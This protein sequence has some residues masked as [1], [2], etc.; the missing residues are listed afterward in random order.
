MTKT[1]GDKSVIVG[2]R[3]SYVKMK[4]TRLIERHFRHPGYIMGFTRAIQTRSQTRDARLESVV[5]VLRRF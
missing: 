2:A 1:T 5:P 3:T 4:A